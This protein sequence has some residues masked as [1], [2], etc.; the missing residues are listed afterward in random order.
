MSDRE[1][2]AVW[3]REARRNGRRIHPLSRVGHGLAYLS[4]GAA[5]A[6]PA[7][8]FLRPETAF[9]SVAMSI[10]AGTVG[11]AIFSNMQERMLANLNAERA[12]T[13]KIRAEHEATQ[14]TV[15]RINVQQAIAVK[16]LI[17][18]AVRHA[19]DGG[20]WLEVRRALETL[21]E[22]YRESNLVSHPTANGHNGVRPPV[23][24]PL[25]TPG[26]GDGGDGMISTG[27]SRRL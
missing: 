9:A 8:L 14:Q 10:V 12:N 18:V 5:I 11:S 25:P 19:G 22:T 6:P 13:D 1:M 2:Q 7:M 26:L 23:P 4:I 3:Q 20:D 21:A 17:D 16:S 24:P 15:Q 27:K